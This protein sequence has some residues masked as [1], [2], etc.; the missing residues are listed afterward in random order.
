MWSGQTWLLAV[1]TWAILAIGG[2]VYLL[3]ER[4]EKKRC[5]RKGCAGADR[6][7]RH[8]AEASVACKSR[9]HH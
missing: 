7:Q 5:H 6:I 8:E 9:P 4:R 1:A 2:M 3:A